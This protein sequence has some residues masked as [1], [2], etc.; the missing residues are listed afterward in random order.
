MDVDFN[1]GRREAGY[2]LRDSDWE[3]RVAAIAEAAQDSGVELSQSHGP[4]FNFADPEVTDREYYEEITRRSVVASARLGVKWSVFH[5]GTAVDENRSP[6]VSKRRNYE[7][8]APLI[9]TAERGGMGIAIE[10]MQEY[11]AEGRMKPRRRYTAGVEEQCELIDSFGSRAVGAA[12]DFGHANITGQDQAKA[13]SYIGD[14]LKATHVH[15]NNGLYDDH[16][17]PFLGTIDWAAAMQALKEIGYEGDFAYEI[18]Y[19]TR[20][21]PDTLI[22]AALRLAFDAGTHLLSLCRDTGGN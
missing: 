15:D 19:F 14:R 2:A 22:D 8:F 3:A 13:L 12:W 17:L 18:P 1:S 6:S 11:L 16:T 9:E 4:Y 21:I 5:A 7:F 20:G 10:N